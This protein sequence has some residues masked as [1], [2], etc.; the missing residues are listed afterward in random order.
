MGILPGEVHQIEIQLAHLPGQRGSYL[1]GIAAEHRILYFGIVETDD[2]L[3]DQCRMLTDGGHKTDSVICQVSLP[4]RVQEAM[5]LSQFMRTLEHHDDLC[6]I[7]IK[8]AGGVQELPFNLIII[9]FKEVDTIP[10]LYTHSPDG[11]SKELRGGIA[12]QGYFD[13]RQSRQ[14]PFQILFKFLEW[15]HL[16]N[17]VFSIQ[18]SR[19]VRDPSGKRGCRRGRCRCIP[20][21][22]DG[23]PG[24]SG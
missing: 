6:I 14:V 4:L 11:C 3:V 20:G 8:L 18:T 13:R 7:R 15:K 19:R 23:I 22:G 24:R 5:A 16:T 1:V 12:E 2:L 21:R 10:S 17:C 9:R